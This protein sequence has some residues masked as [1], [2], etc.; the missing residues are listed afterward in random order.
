[1]KTRRLAIS[2]FVR[3]LKHGE[4]FV[5]ESVLR[6]LTL[7]LDMGEDAGLRKLHD[8]RETMSDIDRVLDEVS[9]E[10]ASAL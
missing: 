5:R 6:L 8:F 2:S 3:S 10:K 4:K 9:A 1:M 7:W